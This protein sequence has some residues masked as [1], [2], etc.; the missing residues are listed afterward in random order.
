[1]SGTLVRY[2]RNCSTTPLFPTNR[3]IS[4]FQVRLIR[5][6][7]LVRT[8][9]VATDGLLSHCILLTHQS[10]WVRPLTR[11]PAKSHSTMYSTA[12]ESRIWTDR[13]RCVCSVHGI[14]GPLSLAPHPLDQSAKHGRPLLT[15]PSRQ[16]HQASL[17][18]RSGGRKAGC[19]GLYT[20]AY[21]LLRYVPREEALR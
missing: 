1:M 8:P 4:H 17:Y 13:R 6:P 11:P 3:G 9:D 5:F 10:R 14:I 2:S 21:A 7:M 16:Y 18:S 12:L 20:L 15:D 19:Q